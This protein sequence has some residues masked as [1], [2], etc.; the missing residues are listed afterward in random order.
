MLK[1]MKFLTS[2]T[3]HYDPCG[4]ISEMRV[5]NKNV[6]YAHESRLEIKKFANQM[7]WEPNN[8]MDVEP[9]IEV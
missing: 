4:I 6:P 7:E 3:W 8:L 9:P 2:F 1:E 5:K